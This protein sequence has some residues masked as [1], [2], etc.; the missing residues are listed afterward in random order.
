MSGRSR[1]L[2]QRTATSSTIADSSNARRR[3]WRDGLEPLGD[4]RGLADRRLR[5]WPLTSEIASLDW[6]VRA[7]F[8]GIVRGS[9]PKDLFCVTI[10]VNETKETRIDR[11]IINRN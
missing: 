11:I 3:I 8:W 2:Q 5:I 10:D 6:K 1:R 7:D 4:R 9:K